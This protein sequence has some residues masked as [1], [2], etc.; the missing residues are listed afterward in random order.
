M[1]SKDGMAGAHEVDQHRICYYGYKIKSKV[2]SPTNTSM[3]NQ[4]RSTHESS[5]ERGTMGTVSP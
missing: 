2:F 5:D 4:T 3:A 1:H